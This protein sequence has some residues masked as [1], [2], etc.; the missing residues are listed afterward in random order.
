MRAGASTGE[1]SRMWAAREANVLEE[2]ITNSVQLIVVRIDFDFYAGKRPILDRQCFLEMLALQ[3][4][5]AGN[6]SNTVIWVFILRNYV[7]WCFVRNYEVI[8]VQETYRFP[9]QSENLCVG[10]WALQSVN[11][12]Y[13]S[14]ALR[15]ASIQRNYVWWS[16]VR[17]LW[18]EFMKWFLCR[19]DAYLVFKVCHLLFRM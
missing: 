3:P 6:L 10:M 11:A 5:N 16:F 2:A 7:H 13:L 9:S 8:I 4:V 12:G 19:K 18:I 17:K 14:N 15:W 1:K